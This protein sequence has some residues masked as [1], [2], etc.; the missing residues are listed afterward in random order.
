MPL[1]HFELSSSQYRLLAE[2][3]VAPVPD[4]ATAEA[5]QRECLARG[6][7]PDDV[8]ADASELLL[9]GLVVRE[10]RALA[11]TP[12]GAAV[13]YRL[14]HEEA[15]QRL[16][17]VVQVAEAADDVSPR[18]ARAVRQLAQGSLSLGEALAEVGG[19]D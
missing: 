3:I 16:A 18:L 2:A 15:E 1:P 10:R 19:G 7:D 6:L 4:P 11:L 5:A 12:L 9:L 14:A 13:H 17:A 8:R